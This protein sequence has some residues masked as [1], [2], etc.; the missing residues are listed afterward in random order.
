MTQP[1][2]SENLPLKGS[3]P[4]DKKLSS[5][6][7]QNRKLKEDKKIPLAEFLHKVMKKH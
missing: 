1:P 7:V 6:E 5:E 4:D 2:P 3:D